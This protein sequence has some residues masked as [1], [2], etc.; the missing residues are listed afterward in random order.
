MEQL[1]FQ[2][3]MLSITPAKMLYIQQIIQYLP[4]LNVYQ[5]PIGI[6]LQFVVPFIL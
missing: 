3:I 1:L 5:N 6:K 2:Q 4:Q